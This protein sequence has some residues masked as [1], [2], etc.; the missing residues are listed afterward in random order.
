MTLLG[1]IFAPTVVAAALYIVVGAPV[2]TVG[3]RIGAP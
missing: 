2:I 3:P 1:L